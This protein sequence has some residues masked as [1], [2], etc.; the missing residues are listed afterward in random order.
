MGEVRLL[1]DCVPREANTLFGLATQDLAA[2][3]YSPRLGM[4][5]VDEGADTVDVDASG[6][7]TL[8]FGLM[9]AFTV[10]VHAKSSFRMDQR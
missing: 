9:P 7:T 3:G 6:T 1:A 8:F 2:K 4:V 10:D 5:A